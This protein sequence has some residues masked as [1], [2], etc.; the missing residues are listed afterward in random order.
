MEQ[1]RK[2]RLSKKYTFALLAIALSFLA[3][4]FVKELELN[5]GTSQVAIISLHIVILLISVT[6]I[7]GQAKIDL[8]G[9]N[10]G[11]QVNK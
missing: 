9:L 5:E 1:K 10:I 8:S 7:T 4:A 2:L 11:A 6:Y 3:V